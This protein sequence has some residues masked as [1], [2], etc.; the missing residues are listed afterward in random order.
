MDKKGAGVILDSTQALINKIHEQRLSLILDNLKQRRRWQTSLTTISFSIS[1][2][3]V[4]ILFGNQNSLSSWA[5]SGFFLLLA[6]GIV[7]SLSIKEILEKESRDLRVLNAP[8]ELK[9]LNK[10][11]AAAYIYAKKL[12]GID[13]LIKAELDRVNP[14]PELNKDEPINYTS[15]ITLG[16]LVFGIYLLVH[17]LIGDSKIYSIGLYFIP[18]LFLFA[19]FTSAQKMKESSKKFEKYLKDRTKHAEGYSNLIKEINH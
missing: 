2:A 9:L 1:A 16:F 10:Q 11:K 7:E 5:T 3:A 15:D 19:A 6:S 18:S 13:M 8:Y 4:P 17:D 14:D 12:E